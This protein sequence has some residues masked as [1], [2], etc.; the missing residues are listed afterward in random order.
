MHAERA[1][2]GWG[3][4]GK[5]FAFTFLKGVGAGKRYFPLRMAALFLS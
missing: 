5:G 3:G 2:V 1:G 4:V